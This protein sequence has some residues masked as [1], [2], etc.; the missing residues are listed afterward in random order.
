[1]A[2]W[3]GGEVGQMFFR[4]TQGNFRTAFVGTLGA[5]DDTARGGVELVPKY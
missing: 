2:R 5:F 3:R 1:V 4:A